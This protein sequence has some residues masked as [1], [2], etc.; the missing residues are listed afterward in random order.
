LW[1]DR[2][3]IAG[4]LQVEPVKSHAAIDV[5]MSRYSRYLAIML[6]QP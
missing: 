1:C 3:R 4:L 2:A 5:I 6:M